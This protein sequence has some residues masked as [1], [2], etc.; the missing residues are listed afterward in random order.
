MPRSLIPVLALSLL[1]GCWRDLEP[2][3]TAEVPFTNPNARTQSG[4]V[5]TYEP[6]PA[7]PCPDGKPA[8]FYV[9]YN[10]S[11]TQETEPVEGEESS[12]D[13]SDTGEASLPDTASPAEDEEA[14]ENEPAEPATKP[15]PVALI[16]HSSAFDYAL[17]P[18]PE[19]PIGGEHFRPGVDGDTRMSRDWGI[20]KVWATLGLGDSIDPTEQNEG[21]LAAALVDEGM[22]GILPI[23]CWGDLWHNDPESAPNDLVADLGVSRTGHT[24]AWWMIRILHDLEFALSHNVQINLNLDP[25]E[26]YLVGLG[27]GARGVLDLL[28]RDDMP[29]VRGVLLDA[30]VADLSH[31]SASDFPGEHAGLKRIYNFADDDP[32]RL[33]PNWW[34]HSIRSLASNG[35]LSGVHTALLYSDADPRIPFPDSH[36]APL[37][38]SLSSQPTTWLQNVGESAHVF[39]NANEDRARAVVEFLQTGVIPEEPTEETDTGE[40][41]GDDTDSSE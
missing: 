39:S 7:L 21:S 11:K 8:R 2:T 12:G 26:L 31:W 40:A 20:Q 6:S 15:S 4:V 14:G 24:M 36:Y 16:L 13:T 27:D 38:A 17:S 32:E 29:A 1:Q 3:V 35:A 34:S 5:L 30:P 18:T 37:L 23:N 19:A 28:Q 33:E 10:E 9:L 22:V 25:S 41:G